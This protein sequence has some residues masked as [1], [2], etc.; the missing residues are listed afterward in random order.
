MSQLIGITGANGNLG[1]RLIKTIGVSS[2]R[3]LV[4]SD[5]AKQ[6]LL[7]D[8]PE[9]DVQIVDYTNEDSL[10]LGLEGCSTVV[11]LVGILK[12]NK[13]SNYLT[14]HENSCKALVAALPDSVK[15]V[16]YLSIVG[17]EAGHANACLASKGNAE[18]ILLKGPADVLV[19]QVPMVLGEGDYASAALRRNA[20]KDKVTVF[21]GSSLEQPIYA[22]DVVNA[23]IAATQIEGK[24]RLQLAG[25]ESLPRS[26]LIQRAAN[27]RGRS[28][29]VSS[30]PIGLGLTMA[31]F[32]ELLPNPPVTRAML[33]VLDHDDQVEFQ[34][35]TELLGL[36]LTSLDDMLKL[37]TTD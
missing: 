17:S 28:V 27:V 21:R 16:I 15:Q 6:S 32:L 22:G 13:Q 35:A 4:R 18:D 14:A 7:S 23:I 31:F 26:E 20:E 12:E 3:A 9:L 24:H 29:K 10:R 11:H 19:L 5:R 8:F 34:Q 25:P 30:L 37:T 33:G 36:Q 1:V 2:V